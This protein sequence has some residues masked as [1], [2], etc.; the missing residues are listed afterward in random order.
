MWTIGHPDRTLWPEEGAPSCEDPLINSRRFFRTLALA[1]TFTVPTAVSSQVVMPPVNMGGTSFMD[2][3]AG[4]GTLIEPVIIDRY[5]ASKF[6]DSKGDVIPGINSVDSWA[7]IFHAAHIT[8]RQIFGGFY[9]AEFLVP[10]ASVDLNTAFGPKGKQSGL[11]DILVSPLILEWPGKTLG[12]KTFFSRF[13]VLF[14]LPT[15]SYS[16]AR[17]VNIGSNAGGAF[18]YYAFTI[19]PSKKLETSWRINYRWNAKNST[20]FTPLRVGSTQ[21]GQAVHANYAMSYEMSPELRLGVNGYVLQ[22]LTEH[23]LDTNSIAN[24]KERVVAIGPGVQ[25]SSGF[26]SAIANVDFETMARNRPEGYRVNVTLRRV[27]P[28]K[29]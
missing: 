1:A 25:L 5:H 29:R 20:P 13:S 7:Y 3:V 16:A 9:G 14:E 22:Q 26:W 19:F 27:F 24:S 11:G 10:Y 8:T 17:P 23:R 2:G 28:H 12:G 4:P 21:A 6:I 18:A 15:G